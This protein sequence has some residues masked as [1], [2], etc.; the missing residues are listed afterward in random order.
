MASLAASNT[1]NSPSMGN[2][3]QLTK[4]DYAQMLLEIQKNNDLVCP[5][6]KDVF[7][8]PVDAVDGN[9]YERN[10]IE[11]WF[12]GGNRS[13][14]LTNLRLD[15]ITLTPNNDKKKLAEYT[16]SILT[17]DVNMIGII[18][19]MLDS[20]LMDK[21]RI[22]D[23]EKEAKKERQEKAE[24][25]KA[26]K[27]AEQKKKEAEEKKRREE[28]KERKRKEEKAAAEEKRRNQE[29]ERI[30]RQRKEAEEQ[31][32][33]DMQQKYQYD[34]QAYKRSLGLVKN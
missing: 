2:T 25:K 16:K 12:N 21:K 32:Q 18:L 28:E 15:D 11:T 1:T 22:K 9:T 7:T 31:R 20:Q 19:P 4:D 26:L 24:A 30:N 3:N 29:A 6:T 23:L 33:R 14:P 13:S 8:D 27:E 17:L 34:V 5:L 10:S